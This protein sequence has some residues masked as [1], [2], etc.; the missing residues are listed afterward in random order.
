MAA[1]SVKCKLRDVSQVVVGGKPKSAEK[2]DLLTI[3]QPRHACRKVIDRKSGALPVYLTYRILIV[4][5]NICTGDFLQ[6]NDR[7]YLS[8]GVLIQPSKYSFISCQTLSDSNWCERILTFSGLTIQ[9][10]DTPVAVIYYHCQVISRS[11]SIKVCENRIPYS[12]YYSREAKAP[13][14]VHSWVLGWSWWYIL[15]GAMN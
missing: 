13:R 12:I 4:Q 10:S 9:P 3:F 2:V 11:H 8:R 14:W 15:R 1:S 7:G 6:R 5:Q